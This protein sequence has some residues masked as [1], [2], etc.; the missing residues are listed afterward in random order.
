MSRGSMR[1]PDCWACRA[2]PAR[3]CSACVNQAI[4]ER[5][6][7]LSEYAADKAKLEA[8]MADGLAARDALL[9]QRARHA[10]LR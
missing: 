8:A 2:T 10:H 1:T 9:R 7:K 5:H 6:A 3:F 4:S